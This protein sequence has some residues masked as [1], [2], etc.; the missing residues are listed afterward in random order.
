MMYIQ[1][2]VQLVEGCIQSQD[3]VFL[4][5]PQDEI[6]TLYVRQCYHDV[7]QLLIQRINLN[8][9]SFAI[10]GTRGIGK[11]LFFVHILYRLMDNFH[12]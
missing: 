11:S 8:K 5:Y 12:K 6:Q 7:F 1:A 9:K 3:Q 2:N 10:S 4:P